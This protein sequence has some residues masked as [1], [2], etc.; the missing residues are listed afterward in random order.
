MAR[1][2]NPTSS[3]ANFLRA[4]RLEKGLAQLEV[5][6]RTGISS[7]QLS[8]YEVGRMSPELGNLWKLCQVYDKTLT[9]AAQAMGITVDQ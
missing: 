2:G 5:A 9:Q 8:G 4:A 3:L 1:T 7:S 6:R